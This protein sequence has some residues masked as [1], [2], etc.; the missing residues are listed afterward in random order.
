MHQH[1]AAK[2]RSIYLIIKVSIKAQDVRVSEMALYF[3]F[4]AKLMLNL[5]LLQLAL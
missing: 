2:V 1:S 3:N 5:G 4:S